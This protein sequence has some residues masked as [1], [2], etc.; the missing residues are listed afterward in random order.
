ML[1]DHPAIA[2]V[3]VKDLA[4]AK[5]F[6]QDKLDLKF[7]EENPQVLTFE[8]GGQLLFVYQSSFAGTNQATAITWRLDDVDGAAADL[9]S[10]GVT[11]EHYDNVPELTLQ[12]DLYKGHGMTV[13]WF[14]DPDGNVISLV[15]A[16]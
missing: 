16:G 14:K 15:S 6:Y 7:I 9:K 13:C 2:T 8:A 1:A 11:F 5:P 4:R 3:A 10:R 12:G